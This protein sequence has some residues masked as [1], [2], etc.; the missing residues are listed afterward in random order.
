MGLSN[1][2]KVVSKRK[3]R[4]G[5]GYG[6]GRGGHTVGRGTKGQKARG[7][8]KLSF[9][10]G[11]LPLVRRLPKRGGFRSFRGKPVVLNLSDLDG[12][13]KGETVSPKALQEKGLLKKIPTAGV[14]V[15]GRGAGRPLK[16][17][18]I[19]LSAKA[20]DKIRKAGGEIIE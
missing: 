17:E 20:R 9:E 18:R 15:L 1:L 3:R 16:F 19:S 10:G 5:R 12:F 13:R 2:S 14:K 8:V 6:S 4:V 11:Q 7:K